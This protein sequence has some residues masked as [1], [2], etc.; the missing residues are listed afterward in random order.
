[1]PRYGNH[2]ERTHKVIAMSN[3]HNPCPQCVVNQRCCRELSGLR[4][5]K[6]EFE[7][8]FKEYSSRL[9][10][11]RHGNMYIVSVKDKIPCPHWKKNQCSIYNDRPI[12][13]MLYPYEIYRIIEDYNSLNVF[14][15]ENPD[16]PHREHLLISREEVNKTI[17]TML[18]SSY[19]FAKKINIVHRKGQNIFLDFPN[20]AVIA[21]K[22]I[23]SNMR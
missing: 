21:L 20:L 11:E 8:N 9:S 16:C 6:E 12:D 15:C 13:C 2:Q 4:L 23:F 10:I 18:S 14:V 3:Q 7:K 5:S 17:K 22:R 1:M 19:G